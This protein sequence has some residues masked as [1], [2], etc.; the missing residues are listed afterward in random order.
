[1]ETTTRTPF[2][3]QFAIRYGLC[4]NARHLALYRHLGSL[5]S[6]LSLLAGMGAMASLIGQTG[7]LSTTVGLLV[8]TVT[9]LDNQIGPAGRI[10]CFSEWHA[11]W[12][13]LHQLFVRNGCEAVI[14]GLVELE[15]THSFTL[16]GLGKVAYNDAAE[17]LGCDT[18][19]LYK[20]DLWPRLLR[21]FA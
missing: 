10:Q 4:L 20:L 21:L 3:I 7:W 15:S 18:D 9:V 6:G 13:A 5:F 8:A 19:S 2:E 11:K 14:N 12:S 16:S 17:E 1:M